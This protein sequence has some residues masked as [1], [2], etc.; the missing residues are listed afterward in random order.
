MT[1]RLSYKTIAF[2]TP[3]IVCT[4]KESKLKE[5]VCDMGI[6]HLLSETILFIQSLIISGNR[7]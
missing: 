7:L 5:E 2:M 3:E 6:G 4:I 1:V